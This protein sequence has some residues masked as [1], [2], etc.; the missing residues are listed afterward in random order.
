MRAH[1]LLWL[2]LV[3]APAAS[4]RADDVE[5]TARCLVAEN[6]TGEDW[7]AI[8]D[9]LERRAA[10]AG[11]TVGRMA[12]LYCAVHRAGSPTQ[13]QT[14]IRALP[15]AGS[16]GRLLRA[17]QRALVAARRGGPGT[18]TANHWGDRGRDFARATRLGWT[19]V[20]CGETRNAF[21]LRRKS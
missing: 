11:V 13:R 15:A 14:R 16:P 5:D 4:A 18:C 1:L 21:W 3:A 2:A 12:R 6:V 8:L 17:Y 9:V 7:P 10:Q 19:S 20:V